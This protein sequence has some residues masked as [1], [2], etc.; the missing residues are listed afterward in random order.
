SSSVSTTFLVQAYGKHMFTC[1]IVCE[2][3]KR[4]VCGIDIMSGNPPDEP[5]NVSCIQHGMDGHPTCT[6]DKG[7]FTHIHTTY[8]LQ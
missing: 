3:K 8:V 2:H 7:R 1:K 6:W 5:H 4:L